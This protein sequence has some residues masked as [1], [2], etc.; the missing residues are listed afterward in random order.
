[1][2]ILPKRVGARFHSGYVL[3]LFELLRVYI[4]F[5]ML[6]SFVPF[7]FEHPSMTLPGIHPVK[8]LSAFPQSGDLFSST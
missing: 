7:I 4:I 2:E 5:Q 8:V 6:A 1:M 3:G